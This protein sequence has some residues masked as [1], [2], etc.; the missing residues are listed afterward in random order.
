MRRRTGL[1]PAL[2]AGVARRAGYKAGMTSEATHLESALR[3]WASGD[4]YEA[5]EA[6]EEVV[7]TLDEDSADSSFGL[8][9]V[10]VAAALHKH[11]AQVG[12]E[13]VPGKLRRALSALRSAP[14][15]WQGL[16]L[17]G[18]RQGIEAFLAGGGSLPVLRRR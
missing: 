14:A 18:L 5:H 1:G 10:H 4:Y 8:A 6:L 2:F 13:A 7:E 3:Y 16:D 15:D 9:L 11:V 12:P 17:D